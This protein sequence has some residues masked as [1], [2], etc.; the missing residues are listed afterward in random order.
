MSTNQNIQDSILKAIDTIA[1]RRIDQLKLDKTITAIINSAVGVVNKRKIYKVEYEGGY[2]NA[3][4]QNENDAYLPR[5]AVYVQVPE[6]DFSKE[7]FILGKASALATDAQI[8][9]VAATANNYSITG[10]NV[11]NNKFDSIGLR[12]YHD[13]LEENKDN[14]SIKHRFNFLYQDEE[15][16]NQIDIF[17]DDLSLYK[18]DATAIMIRADFMTRLTD[19]QKRKATG[20]YGLVFNL[21]FD[22]LAAGVGET[23]GDVFNYYKNIISITEEDET[24]HSLAD[25]DFEILYALEHDTFEE[26]IQQDGI[27]DEQLSWIQEIDRVY[28]NN[29][30]AKYTDTVKDLI[31]KYS[32][33]LQDM[34]RATTINR[35]KDIRQE[36]MDE[37][38]GQP[39]EK[40]VSYYLSS[41]DMIGN[42]FSFSSWMSQYEVFE[43]DLENFLRVDSVLFY[44]QGFKSNEVVESLRKE[45]ILVKD[46]QLYMMR[47]L[48]DDSAGYQLKVEDKDNGMVFSGEN[49][50]ATLTVKATLFREYYEDLSRNSDTKFYWF[51]QSE[52]ITSATQDDYNIY[53]GIG[54]KEIKNQ[55]TLKLEISIKETLA[56][57]NHYRCAVV[58]MGE[59]T[60][61]V[62]RYDFIVYNYAGQKFILQSDLG[63][64]FTFDAGTPILTVYKEEGDNL[65]DL[66]NNSH[67]RFKWAIIDGNNQKTF[68]DE[69]NEIDLTNITTSNYLNYSNKSKLLKGIKWYCGDEDITDF[70]T[71][72]KATKIQ[73][74][75]S[76]ISTAADVT[77]EC[78]ISYRQIEDVDFYLLGKAMITLNNFKVLSAS[79]YRIWI[80]NGDQVFQYDEYGNSPAEAKY[81]DPQE[82]LP[83]K[84]HLYAP[85]NIE[86]QDSSFRVKWF[87]P[88]GESLIEYDS[89][90]AEVD[91]ATGISNL[92]KTNEVGFKIKKLYDYN[93][94]DNQINCQ[95]DFNNQTLYS[96]TTFNFT[97][98]GNNGTNG[99]DVVAKIVPIETKNIFYTQPFT[100]Y[101]DKEN[102]LVFSNDKPTYLNIINTLNLNEHLQVKLYQK[103]QEIDDS[104][105]STRWNIAGNTSTANN[106]KG[107]NITIENGELIWNNATDKQ[108]HQYILKSESVYDKKS[109]YAFYS[110]PVIF[111]QSRIPLQESAR[112]GINNDTYLKEVIYNAD[113]RNPLYNHNQGL[114]LLNLHDDW[115]VIFEARGGYNTVENEPNFVLLKD[116]IQDTKIATDKNNAK[117]YILPNDSFSGAITNNH[118]RATVYDANDEIVAIVIAPI[119]M[120]LN[121]YGLASLNAWDGNSVT[122]D[123]DEGYIMA[124]QIGAGYK[125]METNLFTGAV[126]GQADDYS[127]GGE[128]LYTGLIGYK[129][130]MRS[131]FLDAETGNATF[132][133]PTL[134]GKTD[135]IKM[136]NK[137]EEKWEEVDNYGEGLIELRPNDVSQIG[138]W[139]FGRR[140]LYYSATSDADEPEFD[141]ELINGY[142]DTD[143]KHHTKDIK[144]E[145][146]GI[147]VSAIPPYISIKGR[148]LTENDKLDDS[149]DAQVKAGDS[150]ELQLDPANLTMFGIYRHYKDANQ[151]YTRTLLS[152]INDKGQL[153]ANRMEQAPVEENPD[154]TKSTLG[155]ESFAAFED[156][157]TQQSYLGLNLS[158]GPSGIASTPAS[159]FRFFINRS[160]AYNKNTSA[161]IH[162]TGGRTSLD[163]DYNRPINV[164]GE[165]I[166]LYARDNNNSNKNALTT[167]AYIKITKTVGEIKIG[168]TIL[169]LQRNSNVSSSLNTNNNFSATTKD[170]TL[171]TA[172]QTI[173]STS[174]GIT[175]TGGYTLT[176]EGVIDIKTND[177][178]DIKLTRNSGSNI[179]IGAQS[180][181]SKINDDN[182]F[183]LNTTSN[184]S[185]AWKSTYLMELYSKNRVTIKA[186]G[187]N[188][189]PGGST[190]TNNAMVLQAGSNTRL[191]MQSRTNN[192]AGGTGYPFYLDF[193]S[194]I[195]H[196]LVEFNAPNNRTKW[197]MGMNQEVAMG[198]KVTGNYLGNDYGLRVDKNAS[199][200]GTITSSG[201]ITT[202]TGFTGDGTNI[203]HTASGSNSGSANIT[204][205]GVGGSGTAYVPKITL[206]NGRPSFSQE[207]LTVNLPTATQIWNAISGSVSSAISSALSNYAKT[208][209]LDD[210]LKKGVNYTYDIPLLSGVTKTTT[211][212]KSGDSNVTVVTDVNGTE[213]HTFRVN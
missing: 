54:W 116:D 194:S 92:F 190:A 191:M 22:N 208:S 34:K 97:K 93:A 102:D 108:Y 76:N 163:G 78:Y 131:F 155:I 39:A 99:T 106:K 30:P 28:K 1:Q 95:I 174:I 150:I 145:N 142:T 128:H 202:N 201:R 183:K 89:L 173:T 147:L 67:Y 19:E 159:F 84:V 120:S 82:I 101:V 141:K 9:V 124:P 90:E 11:V 189:S 37:I 148:T 38:I 49:E 18:N 26:I 169:E 161:P 123:E 111:Y 29:N 199:F 112:I 187:D 48:S 160:D 166:N 35:M 72:E 140:S 207:S 27:I 130:G 186:D 197:Y 121:T 168:S 144:H 10:K 16:N 60:P 127:S 133:Y 103:S 211:T 36:W 62:L 31:E 203:T 12:S 70:S 80:E 75:M 205:S 125:D 188:A 135:K 56:F 143:A 52:A 41:N 32:A 154:S 2:F 79:S 51:K 61:I 157:D 152:G 65:I 113:G 204:I 91:P 158:G 50:N 114:E 58:Y 185:S 118:I 45:D 138:G 184:S 119:N 57:E 139:R 104:E 100:L 66:S 85:N 96:E 69:T 129:D 115:A 42:P 3:T 122:I 193:G 170:L 46:I 64:D 178:A 20:E 98:V 109:Y 23:Q 213:R 63:T 149:P 176:N 86:V 44:Q 209:D 156:E 88:I 126:M 47:P 162:I 167:D 81:K 4:A 172:A 53:G 146:Q 107:R 74:P 105:Y 73:Y 94:I 198:L 40:I 71:K 13:P 24:T 200:G 87:F 210:Y 33:M 180:I 5:M 14:T 192:F 43:I 59:D 181:T 175:N 83:I 17:N 137:E 6:G 136:Y 117:V 164:H 25:C 8:S 132:G 7:K 171:T 153:V 195:G 15:E 179:I 134:E 55:N 77:F 182:L 196:C 206:T 212:V 177:N 165:E 151:E 21:A 110:L 68:L